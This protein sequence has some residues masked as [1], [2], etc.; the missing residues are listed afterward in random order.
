M[1][2]STVTKLS[3]LDFGK[4]LQIHPLH[5][6]QVTFDPPGHRPNICDQAYPQYD[7]QDADRVSRELIASC[8]AEAETQLETYLKYRLAPAWEVDEWR[9]ME[10]PFRPELVNRN[11]NDVRGYGAAVKAK[12]G[13]LISGG[14]RSKELIEEAASIV[15]TDADGDG[16]FETATVTVTVDADIN[17]CELK[18]YYPGHSGDDAWEIKPVRS[19][20]IGTT[21]TIVFRREQCVKEEI[22]EAYFIEA[23]DGTDDDSFL[24][25]VDIYRVYNDPQTQVS[26]LWEPFLSPCGCNG[27]G[28]A[29]CAYTIQSGCLHLRGNPE[30]SMVVPAPATWDGDTLSFIPMPW[31]TSRAPDIARLYYYAGWRDKTL[32]CNQEMAAEW[33]RVVAY[34]GASMLDRAPCSC[35]QSQW[36]YWREDLALVAGS[37]GTLEQ[38]GRYQIS[39][40]DLN[41]PFGTRR[42]QVYA[43]KRVIREASLG[44]AIP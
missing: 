25:E 27:G 11:G 24:E 37:D 16:Y 34:M 17:P 39:S 14:I 36:Q 23:V 28:C 2:A 5:L 3:L 43:W 33:K 42:G 18:V 10:R 6:G 20:L 38:T 21:A 35:V 40:Q 19:S 44:V 13:H 30:S 32:S 26:F 7:W 29:S 31:S 41:N 8:I 12:W 15:Y 1:R 22:T 9:A 4:M